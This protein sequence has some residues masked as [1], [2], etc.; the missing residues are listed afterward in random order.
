MAWAILSNTANISQTA[1][2]IAALPSLRLGIYKQTTDTP[3]SDLSP[4]LSPNLSGFLLEALFTYA[5]RAPYDPATTEAIDVLVNG[6]WAAKVTQDEYY[7]GTSWCMSTPT[8]DR[9]WICLPLMLIRGV[10]RRRTCLRSMFLGFSLRR[11]GT[12]NGFSGLA[13]TGLTWAK[14]SVPTPY[15]S[16]EASWRVDERGAEVEL[17][18]KSCGINTMSFSKCCFQGFQWQGTPTG[19]TDKLAN[20]DV[21]ITGDDKDVALLFIADLFGW[22]FPNVRLLADHFARE[23]GATVYVPD[24]FGGEILHD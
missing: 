14:G 2:A 6:L 7:T 17:E 15:G 12:R 22:T 5:R 24:Y 13:H 9:D 8:E 23:L 18:T 11:P 1:S 19:R 4:N 10:V 21:Y 16:I 3:S 20:I